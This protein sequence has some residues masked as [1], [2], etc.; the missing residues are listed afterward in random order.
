MDILSALYIQGMH[1]R[2]VHF[3]IAL[4]ISAMGLDVLSLFLKKENLHR[5]AVHMYVLATLVTPLVVLTGLSEAEH[6]HLHHPVLNLH[7]TF[8]LLTMSTSFIS[9]P[10]LWIVKKKNA[11]A[12][13]TTFFLFALL[14]VIFVSI[15]GYNGGRMVYEYGVGVE[16]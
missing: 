14:S 6:L 15:T 4:F 1:P 5:T 8:A 11:K 16:Q 10:I 3:P 2:S 12:F 13:R 7:K 9:L